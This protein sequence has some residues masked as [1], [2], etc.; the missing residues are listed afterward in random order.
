MKQKVAIIILFLACLAFPQTFLSQTNSKPK[1]AAKTSKSKTD[2]GK[3]Q[4]KKIMEQFI[5]GV[6]IERKVVETFERFVMFEACDE[7]DADN[8]LIQGCFLPELPK[9]LSRK[10]NSK[11]SAVLWKSVFGAYFYF[12]GKNEITVGDDGFPFLSSEYEKIEADISKKN[13]YL[14][15]KVEIKD[16]SQSE[17]EKQLIIKEKDNQAIER[18]VFARIDL[19]LYKKNIRLMKSTIKIGKSV[20]NDRT[21]YD[22]EFSGFISTFILSRKNGE[23]KIIG[24]ADGL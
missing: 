10:T 12:L 9:G 23:L 6:F 20:E 3:L 21:Y 18:A 19:Q 14:A 4:A 15:P 5:D 16:L 8:H 24:L 2:K 11:I 13:T 1:K 17:I 22:V 7:T